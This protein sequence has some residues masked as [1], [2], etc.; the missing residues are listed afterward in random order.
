MEIV[1]EDI[2]DIARGGASDL[3]RPVR[4]K[5]RFG[6]YISLVG[7]WISCLLFELLFRYE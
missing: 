5:I 3:G 1:A 6:L 2:C 4:L 7:N